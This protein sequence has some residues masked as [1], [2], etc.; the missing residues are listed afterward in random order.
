MGNL[1]I[2]LEL[3]TNATDCVI[4]PNDSTTAGA[5]GAFP[6]ADVVNLFT[7][8][9]A[10]DV[11]KAKN[12]SIDFEISNPRVV[13]DLCSL[14]NNLN[15]EYSK[16]LLEAKGLPIT[17]TTFITQSQNIKS[18]TDISVPV[19]RPVSKLVAAFVTFFKKY[20]PL[21]EASRPSTS[22]EYCD[23]EFCRFHHPH[24]QHEP[25]DQGS[26]K[27]YPEYPCNSITQCFYH[28]RSA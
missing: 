21:V 22:Y 28:F 2:E 18:L 7:V 12:P 24:Q 27:L 17:Y 16:H 10:G 14:D 26:S 19:I 23:K 9:E 4:N 8:N 20:D 15:N 3:V 6:V 13:C 5:G 1:E 25:L 11:G